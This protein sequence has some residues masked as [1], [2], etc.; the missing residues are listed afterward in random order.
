MSFAIDFIIDFFDF[1]VD[2]EP[3]KYLSNTSNLILSMQ[4]NQ[5]PKPNVED[6]DE[7][8]IINPSP[9]SPFL[10]KVYNIQYLYLIDIIL[11]YGTI[12]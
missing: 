11:D 2:S 6:K 8:D 5:A 9:C 10:K 3:V 7:K 12:L 1:R 4:Y